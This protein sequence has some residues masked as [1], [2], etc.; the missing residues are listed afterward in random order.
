MIIAI[1][2]AATAIISFIVGSATSGDFVPLYPPLL[3]PSYPCFHDHYSYSQF[4][5][6]LT[7]HRLDRLEMRQSMFSSELELLSRK[8]SE[9]PHHP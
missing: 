9:I 7:E 3:P 4:P 6:R 2:V 1:I 8:V 5:N